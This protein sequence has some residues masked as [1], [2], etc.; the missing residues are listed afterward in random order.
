MSRLV[1]HMRSNAIA[2][3][4]L[5]VALGGTGYAAV[6]LPAGSVGGRQLRNHV[7]QPVKFDP[8]YVGGSV[9]LWASVSAS[10]KVVAGGR[11]VNVVPQGSVAGDYLVS[12]SRG[13]RIATP[14]GCEAL[15]SVDDS[16]AAPG[17]AEAELGVFPHN[18]DLPWQ[19]VVQTFGRDGMP[20]DLPFDLIVVC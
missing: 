7:I 1:G 20:S 11:G 8:R 4:A 18:P 3:V 9:R 13:S 10:G 6:N 14:R 15:A 2:Y 16:S 5:F 17:F 12:P 19:V